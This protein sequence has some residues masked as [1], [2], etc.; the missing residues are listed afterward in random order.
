MHN[1]WMLL[2]R[3]ALLVLLLIS[4]AS[5]A[6]S[7]Q[8]PSVT[9]PTVIVTAEREANDIKE[10]PASVTAVTAQTITDSGLR[11]I[12]DAAIFAPNTVFTEFTARKVSNARFR[13]VGS[14]P[15]NPAITTYI[16]GVPQLNS[17]SSNIELLDVS[18]IEFVRGPQSPLFG[19][20][21]LGGIVNVTSTRP[22]MSR[23]TGSVFAPFGN[24]GQKEVRGSVSGPVGTKT[25]VGIAAGT[26]RRD[27]YTVNGVTGNDLDWRDGTFAKAQVMVL[28]NANWEGRFIYAHE[29]NRDGDYALGDLDAIRATPFH[30]ARD[31]EGFTNRDINSATVNLRGTGQTFAIESTTGFVTWDTEDAT[32]LDYTP[33][34]LATRTNNE[35]DRQ[36]TQEVRI[37]SPENAPVA[38]VRDMMLKWQ[39][40]IEYFNQAYEQDAVNTLAAFVLNPQIPFPVAMH[41]PEAQIDS[42]GIGL[43][44]RGTLTLNESVDLTAGLRFDHESSDAVLR[45][46]FDPVIAPANVVAAEQ[47]FSDVSPQFAA[48]YRV[49]PEHNVYASAAR[50]YKAGG[51]NPASIPGREAFG[52]EHAWHLEGGV[53]STFA[54]GRVAANAALFVIDWDDLQLN[55]PNPFVPAQFY[56]FNVGAARSSGF[57]AEITAKPAAM[58]DVFASFGY[59]RA[60]FAEG[61]ESMGVDVSDN[62][63]PYT[64]D[65]TAL[66]GAQLGRGITSTINAFVR[67]ELVLSGEFQYDETNSRSQEAYSLVNVRAGARSKY[68][69]GELFVRNAFQTRYVPIAIPYQFAQSG[70]IGEN[71]R[72]RTFGVSVGVTF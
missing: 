45:T 9:L 14:S 49:T 54:G 63:L 15:G 12:T 59:T 34:P 39:A 36:F 28:P 62:K 31:F 4:S 66:L 2:N 23:W 71:G 26:Q 51:Y 60:R 57:E 53:K 46:F 64:P 13:G 69:F 47:S 18:Q 67:G 33:L 40:G 70:F 32:D 17:N 44:A 24:V 43:F 8:T 48:R 41:S 58:L 65:Y 68:L 22:S 55:V 6:Q 21:T 19:R 35:A 52:E 38:L 29:R 42:T 30:V 10:V 61:T 20:N 5:F 7:T 3:P 1:G 27:G 16:D 37:A 11:A 56:I 25:A 50:G 72:P